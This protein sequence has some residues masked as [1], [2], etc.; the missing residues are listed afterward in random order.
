LVHEDQLENDRLL[1]Y[2]NRL[3]S[4]CFVLALYANR[5]AGMDKPSLAKGD[6]S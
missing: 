6:P 4:L 3:S 5:Q 2:L 1:V